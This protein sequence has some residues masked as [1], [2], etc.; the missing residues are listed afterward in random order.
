MFR[1]SNLFIVQMQKIN[2]SRL[3]V[4]TL[5][6]MSRPWPCDAIQNTSNS[7][8]ERILIV[9]DFFRSFPGLDCD[10]S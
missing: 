6:S 1:N 8:L 7:R 9:I 10:I 2:R 3:L 5:H 4:Y